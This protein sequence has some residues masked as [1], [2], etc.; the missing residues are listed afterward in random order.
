MSWATGYG[1][2]PCVDITRSRMWNVNPDSADYLWPPSSALMFAG[3][4]AGDYDIVGFNAALGAT[5]SVG[6][7]ERRRRDVARFSCTVF[8]T[9]WYI[10]VRDDSSYKPWM[11]LIA[12]TTAD[13]CRGQLSARLSE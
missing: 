5:V 12:D 1:I 9:P 13:L 4:A 3:L 8:G 10:H 2:P 6:G 7:V 11:M